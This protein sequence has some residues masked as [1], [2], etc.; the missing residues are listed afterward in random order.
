MAQAS[1]CSGIQSQSFALIDHAGSDYSLCSIIYVDESA[2]DR[3]WTDLRKR[4]APSEQRLIE[5]NHHLYIEAISWD[6]PK[7][8]GGQDLGYGELRPHVMALR[9]SIPTQ[10][11]AAFGGRNHEK[12][13]LDRRPVRDGQ[14]H[15]AT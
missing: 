10:L 2:C 7:N 13:T 1:T 11:V 4:V 3:R 5:S 8:P 6:R 14:V 12:H 15:L 9:A